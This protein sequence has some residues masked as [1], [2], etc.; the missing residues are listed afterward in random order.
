MSAVPW[1]GSEELWSR[2]ALHLKQL[3]NRVSACVL[4]WAEMPN[5][6][7]DLESA[8]VEL[9]FRIRL[10]R[11]FP[12]RVWHRLKRGTPEVAMAG[13]AAAWLLKQAPDL[14]CISMGNSQEG[15]QWIGLCRQLG[16]R[17]AI[18]V[19]G[20]YEVS[21]PD[22]RLAEE[23][24]TLFHG[25]RKCFFV[26]QHN[27]DLFQD[28]IAASLPDAGVVRNPFN[29]PFDPDLEWPAAEPFWRL[30]SVGRLEPA[31]KGQDLL[32]R[33]LSAERWKR[34]NLKVS[35]YGSGESFGAGVRKLAERYVPGQVDFQGHVSD[36]PQ[37]WRSNHALI[38]PSRCE[39]MPLA[40]VEAMLCSRM[41]IVTDIAGHSE[42]VSHG[43]NGFL[44]KS[45]SVKHLDAALEE[46]WQRR[47][48]WQAMGRLAR[49]TAL[50]HIP[51]HP[52]A[53]FAAILLALA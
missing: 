30:A 40:L 43:F 24:A 5:R 29:V 7:R 47:D 36:V 16:L 1:G 14:V 21:W 26:S 31:T 46:A 50:S 53:E 41:P 45:P 20:V 33:V 6:L 18:L 17:Y 12:A 8:G 11:T 37:I 19:H 23:M 49:G 32:L 42:L 10:A 22:D 28:Q 34:R 27:L 13:R 15:L 48:E 9:F 38:M 35:F 39:G 3:G 51:P 44:A 25:A 52:E 2:A 4:G